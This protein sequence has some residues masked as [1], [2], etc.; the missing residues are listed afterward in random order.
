[1]TPVKPFFIPVFFQ[2][3]GH[4]FNS[5]Q[6][7]SELHDYVRRY[8][9]QVSTDSCVTNHRTCSINGLAL[10]SISQT[11][12]GQLMRITHCSILYRYITDVHENRTL[13][14]EQRTERIDFRLSKQR[15]ILEY[16]ATSLHMRKML[17]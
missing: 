2:A 17:L 3:H 6:A 1:M 16:P 11:D 8:Q 15:A 10:V 4:E 14:I 9:D 5:D 7:L 13:F 12:V